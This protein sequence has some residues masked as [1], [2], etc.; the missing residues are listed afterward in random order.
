MSERIALSALEDTPS[1]PLQACELS[2]VVGERTLINAVDLTLLPEVI[3]VLM[4]PNGA[5]KSVLLLLLHGLRVPTRGQVLCAGQPLT[6]AHRLR[7]AMLFQQPVL[8]RRSVAANLDFVL[9]LRAPEDRHAERNRLLGDVG[10]LDK[11]RQPAR[12]LSGG[13]QQRLALARVLAVSPRVLFLDEPTA[14]LDPASTALIEN[15][16]RRV[17]QAG[18]KVVFVSHD[19]AQGQRLAD[20]VIFMNH[21]EVLEQTAAVHFFDAPTTRSARDYLAGKLVF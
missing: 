16:V 17:H 1:L 9:K 11:A 4:G 15:V 5:G 18:T 14:N 12:R 21:G 7:Q 3:T 8:L 10:L 6:T 19:A 20:E 2:Y 13:E